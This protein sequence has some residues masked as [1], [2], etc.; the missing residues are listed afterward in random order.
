[1]GRMLKNILSKARMN[2]NICPPSHYVRY[3]AQSVNLDRSD[4][5]S[6]YVDLCAIGGDFYKAIDQARDSSSVRAS[7]KADEHGDD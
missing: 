3:K 7:A 6:L 4:S 1:M 5:E 2:F